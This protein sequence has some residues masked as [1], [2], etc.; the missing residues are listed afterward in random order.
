MARWHEHTVS[1]IM[2]VKNDP[3]GCATT[4]S[5]LATQ[6]RRPDEIVVVDGGS[7]DDTLRVI[8]QIKISLPCLR[9]I[10]LPGS[11]I[12]QGR[13][14]AARQA[15]GEIIACTDSGCRAE[16]DWIE[17]LLTPFQENSAV[18][19]VA[20]F[21]SPDAHSL[22]ERVVGLATMRGQMEP[23]HPEQF[24]PSARSMALTKKLWERSGGWPEWIRFSEDTLFD[25][26]IRR[27]N[28][29]WHF[30]GDAVVRWR[31]RSNLR[32]IARQ[33]YNYATGRGHTRIDAAGYMYNIRNAAFILLAF[34]FCFVSL[35]ALPVLV[36]LVG[37]FYLWAFH[38]KCR[39]VAMMTD[40]WEAYPLCFLV[41]WTIVVANIA[42]FV[43][44]SVQRR[45]NPRQYEARMEAYL[46]GA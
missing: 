30:A 2:T 9:L 26:K 23:V 11:N 1:V 43:V 21:Y 39:R 19:F 20:G 12:A 27:M 28:A 42:G 18:D 17:K 36:A 29:V 22:L 7:T 32:S 16:P 13:N 46:A 15:T 34:A 8:N 44:G 5:A 37:Y 25:H 35:W 10:E 45:R 24:N 40:C 3:V 14:E 31:P 38:Q 41:M 6:T 4:L 33:F